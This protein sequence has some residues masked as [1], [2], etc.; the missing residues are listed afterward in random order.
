MVK[1]TRGRDGR[2]YNGKETKRV[3][4]P[5]PFEKPK[6][7][8]LPPLPALAQDEVKANNI[9]GHTKAS[10]PIPN[11][12]KPT[13]KEYDLPPALTET[14]DDI[15]EDYYNIEFANH[16]SNYE[17]DWMSMGQLLSK[18]IYYQNNCDAVSSEISEYLNNNNM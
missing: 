2:L 9:G 15:S 17:D 5:S 7:S 12:K 18:G 10:A 8:I 4:A 16:N 1:V 6:Q 3:R 11:R 13:F 14:L